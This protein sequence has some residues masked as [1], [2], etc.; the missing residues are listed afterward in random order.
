MRLG[1][2]LWRYVRI[3]KFPALRDAGDFNGLVLLHVSGISQA[4]LTQPARYFILTGVPRGGKR[5]ISAINSSP[6]TPA[7][8]VYP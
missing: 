6:A 1:I 5:Y 3:Y 7:S 4:C 2:V 8:S